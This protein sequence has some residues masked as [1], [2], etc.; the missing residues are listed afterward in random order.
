MLPHLQDSGS[1][2][3]GWHW[4]R[5]WGALAGSVPPGVFCPPRTRGSF[6]GFPS[7]LQVSDPPG[8]AEEGQGAVQGCWGAGVSEPGGKGLALS[9]RVIPEAIQH[10][11]PIPWAWFSCPPQI[12]RKEGTVGGISSSCP[13]GNPLSRVK[14][15]NLLL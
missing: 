10:R 5:A 7:F 12:L 13:F 4:G 9:S 1:S 6:S 8:E 14:C 2:L 3:F 15:H 11:S